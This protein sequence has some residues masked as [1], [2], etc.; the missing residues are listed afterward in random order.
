[1]A[2]SYNLDSLK[3]TEHIKFTTYQGDGSGRDSYIIFNDGGLIPAPNYQG[4]AA[5]CDYLA[6]SHITTAKPA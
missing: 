3:R 5:K 4:M 1:M 2:A 6:K